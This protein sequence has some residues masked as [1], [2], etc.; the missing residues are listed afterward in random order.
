[1]SVIN[2]VN[3]QQWGHM[4]ALRGTDI[5]RVDFVEALGDLKTVPDERYEAAGDALWLTT[6]RV[7]G[8]PRNGSGQLTTHF[9]DDNCALANGG[10]L[11]HD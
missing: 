5:K 3:D 6:P 1:M 9:R 7:G 2:L 4:V 11:P 10:R 8:F